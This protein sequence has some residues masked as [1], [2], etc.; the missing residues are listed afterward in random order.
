MITLE[1]D[2]EPR[3]AE[4]IVRRGSFAVVLADGRTIVVP[5]AWYPRLMYGTVRERKNWRLLGDG[6]AIEWPELDEHISVEGLLAGRKS[7]ESSTS[8]K[9]WLLTRRK[10]A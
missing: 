4:V 1:L 6:Y 5:V 9:K 2:Y 8:V 3:V 7:T 10:A